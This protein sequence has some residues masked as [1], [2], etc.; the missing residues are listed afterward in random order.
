VGRV[1][2]GGALLRERKL[3]VRKVRRRR[4]SERMRG[5]PRDVGEGSM[6][7]AREV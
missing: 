3:G 6:S 4:V 2:S 7:A 1:G 5:G